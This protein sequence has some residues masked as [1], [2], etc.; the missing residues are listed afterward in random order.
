MVSKSILI[1][2]HK[3]DYTKEMKLFIWLKTYL[4]LMMLLVASGRY[5][6]LTW[7]ATGG[8]AVRGC[9]LLQTKH[10]AFNNHK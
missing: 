9:G 8:G 10:L 7:L 2:T 5:A 4:L 3:F 1:L 6:T